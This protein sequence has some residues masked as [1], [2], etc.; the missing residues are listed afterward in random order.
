M[1]GTALPPGAHT[2]TL[3]ISPETRSAGH[4]MRIMRFAA[5]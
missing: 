3:R 5:N 4:A 1:L 2:L